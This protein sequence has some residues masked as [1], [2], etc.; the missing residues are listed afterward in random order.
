ML[1]VDYEDIETVPIS[2]VYPLDRR[3][4]ELRRQGIKCCLFGLS[5]FSESQVAIEATKK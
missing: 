5:S 1:L 3:F 2:S 4:S